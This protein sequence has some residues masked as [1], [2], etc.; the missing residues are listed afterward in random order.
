MKKK[1]FS[2]TKFVTV[3]IIKDWINGLRDV[4]GL[5]Q[6]SYSE[7][8]NTTAKE[9]LKD[10]EAKGDIIWFRQVVDRTFSKTLQ[11]TIYGQYKIRGR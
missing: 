1:N 6:K 8:V 2:V 10:I 3:N 7:I 4:L 9:I 11:I 5:Q